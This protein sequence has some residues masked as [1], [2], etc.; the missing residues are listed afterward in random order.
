MVSGLSPFKAVVPCGIITGSSLFIAFLNLISSVAV[1]QTVNSHT[2][3]WIK[4]EN[5][6]DFVNLKKNLVKL[7]ELPAQ[8]RDVQTP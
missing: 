4:L 5:L 2:N 8:V 1:Q 6:F 3:G 7:V